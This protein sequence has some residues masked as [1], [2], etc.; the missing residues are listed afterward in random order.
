[1]KNRASRY[2]VSTAVVVLVLSF[3]PLTRVPVIRESAASVSHQTQTVEYV[4]GEIVV[5]LTEAAGD[6]LWQDLNISP[7]SVERLDKNVSMESLVR[8]RQKLESTVRE[9]LPIPRSQ[10]VIR[11]TEGT[12]ED[13]LAALVADN[14]VLVAER[15]V[16]WR[17]C[18][19]PND[20]L[21]NGVWQGVFFGQWGPKKLECPRA[22]DKTHGRSPVTGEKPVVGVVDTGFELSHDDLRANVDARSR[23]FTTDGTPLHGTGVA[24]VIGAQW[25]NNLGVAGECPDVSLMLLGVGH[26]DGTPFGTIDS[27][28]V[29]EAV[30]YFV[31][32]NP[33]GGV[34]NMSFGGA[35]SSQA[36]LD[37]INV[38]P[39][40]VCA[41]VGNDGTAQ[42]N[43][44][45]GLNQFTRKVLAVAASDFDDS[46]LAISNTGYGDL[47]APGNGLT[48]IAPGNTYGGISATSAASAS[49]TGIAALVWF[50]EDGDPL[51]V[52][53][54]LTS[55]VDIFTSYQGKVK[56]S[57]RLNAARAAWNERN[58]APPLT[59]SL[60]KSSYQVAETQPVTFALTVSNPDAKVTWAFGDGASATGSFTISH[61][62]Q[63]F[64]QYPLKATV[65]DAFNEIAATAGVT[66]TDLVT[67]KV[68]LK[69][70]GGKVVL[71]ATSSRQ[72]QSSPPV[73][74]LLE[75]GASL[76]YD[77]ESEA[78]RLKVKTNGLPA[79]LTVRSSLGGESSQSWR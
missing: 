49:C 58:P 31:A 55:T 12:E 72:G 38:S 62:Y 7:A 33:K 45:A 52:A 57:G 56:T 10:Y 9:P 1:M 69:S 3:F 13:V 24:G 6:V 4:P 35:G 79:S 8:S 76:P 70:G 36:L 61:A 32:Q 21:W 16:Y 67:L 19:A 25:N 50:L 54:R 66:V 39:I 15:A 47:A 11:T 59:A 78:Y 60:E 23:A 65:T 53:N 28:K 29:I 63:N 40:L 51:R 14:R 5:E 74:T 17:P 46:F 30:N 71:T 77:S 42:I 44:P 18:E 37:T 43:Y 34:L 68:K 2:T 73:L 20:P 26:A 22:W 41:S 75:T 64:G 27:A 48:S